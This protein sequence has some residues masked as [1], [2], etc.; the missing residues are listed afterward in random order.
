[1]ADKETLS[2]Y[3]DYAADYAKRFAQDKPDVHLRKFMT[4]LPTE[5]RVLDLGCGTGRTTAF[6][7]RAGLD[8]EGWDASPEMAEMGLA[9]HELTIRVATFDQLEAVEDYD[10]IF[11]NFSLLHAPKSEMPDH[12][13]R[14]ARALKPGGH[15]HIGLKMGTGEARDKLGRFYAYYSDPEITGLLND[16]GLPSIDRSYGADIGLDG[17]PAPWIILLAQKA[18]Q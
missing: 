6:M 9:Q 13:A 4:A 14:I 17:E 16:V 3:A 11:A 5:A 15:L 10:G 12:L 18:A 8:V 2:V 1:M 7:A